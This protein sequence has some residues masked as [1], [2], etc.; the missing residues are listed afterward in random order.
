MH[1]Y[2]GQF[3]SCFAPRRK[4]IWDLLV[5]CRT[6]IALGVGW[7]IGWGL[8]RVGNNGSIR[9]S[10]FRPLFLVGLTRR[11]QYPNFP[12]FKIAEVHAPL[13]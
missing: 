5:P 4:F 13:P 1:V 8:S 11:V 6:G 12:K 10:A 3:V 2:V 7:T 9:W